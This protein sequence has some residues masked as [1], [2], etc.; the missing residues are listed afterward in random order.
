MMFALFVGSIMF[1]L[2]LPSGGLASRDW[3]HV[4]YRQDDIK[5]YITYLINLRAVC[6]RVSNKDEVSHFTYVQVRFV[7]RYTRPL[8]R[9]GKPSLSTLAPSALRATVSCLIRI[10]LMMRSFG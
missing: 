6:I 10:G 1:T 7:A 9:A 3:I 4:V 2:H 8:L 5:P